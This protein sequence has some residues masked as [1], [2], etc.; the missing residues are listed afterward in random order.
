M[1]LS[2]VK[3]LQTSLLLLTGLAG[4]MSARCPTRDW[5]TVLTV[6]GTLALA[7]GGSTVIN[8]VYDRDIDALMQRAC[9]RPLPAG[10]VSAWEALV[11]GGALSIL[12]LCWSFVVYP[13]YGAVVLAGW[14]FDVVVY[15]VLLKRRTAWS[16][17]WGGIAG[18]M[19]TLA[20]RVLGIGQID[21]IGVLLA[22]AVLLWIPTHMLTFGL[23]YADQYRAAGVPVFA[24]RHGLWV[25]RIAIALSTLAAV[26]AM[27]LAAWHIGIAWRY[28]HVAFWLG[29]GLVGF[30]GVSVLQHS[31]RLNFALYKLASLY[32]LGSMMLIAVGSEV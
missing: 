14:F 21:G 2:L 20:G 15:T 27:L 3:S 7:I 6:A 26:G 9:R 8:M 1:Y 10:Q 32:M 29:T 24:T 5:E 31:P 12:G 22:L 19:P 28:L 17:V 13:L 25:T 23:K 16:I 30:A 4:Y 18:A 11:F